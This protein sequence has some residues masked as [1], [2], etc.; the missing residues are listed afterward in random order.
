MATKVKREKVDLPLQ[1]RQ[2]TFQPSTLDEEARTVELVWTTGAIVRK[3]DWFDSPYEEELLLNDGAVRLGRLNGG[4]NLL[5]SHMG[6]ELSRVLG[7]VEEA[8]LDGSGKQRVGKARVRFSSRPDVEPFYHD[9]KDGIIRNVSVGYA[10]H[11]AQK[12][13]RKDRKI[14]LVRATDWEPL[15]LSMVAVPADVGAQVRSANER[16]FPCVV[17]MMGSGEMATRS[18]QEKAVHGTAEDIENVD[19]EQEETNE[20]ETNEEERTEEDIQERAKGGKGGG[21]SGGKGGGKSGGKGG[22]GRSQEE[23]QPQPQP[24]VDEA[25]IE[26]RVQQRIAEEEIR[27]ARIRKAVQVTG[28]NA[29]I[30]ERAIKAG[31]PANEAVDAILKKA[32]DEQAA[33]QIVSPT[34]VLP[35]EL[36]EVEARGR[37][38]RS[39]ILHR[40]DPTKFP[41][42]FGGENYQGFTLLEL[43]RHCLEAEGVRTAGLSRSELAKRSMLPGYGVRVG[44]LHTTSDF[45]NILADVA[46]KTLRAAYDAAVRTFAPFTRRTT[47]PDFKTVNRMQLGEAPTLIRKNEHGEFQRGTIG[48]SKE[49]YALVTYGRVFGITREVVVNDDLQAFTR[50]PALFGTAAAQK[51]S[52]VVWAVILANAAMGDGTAL[53]H[54][55]HGNLKASGSGAPSVTTIGADRAAMSKQTG[56]DGKTLINV[57]ARYILVPPELET[58]A[59]QLVASITAAT[60]ANVVPASIRSL[61]PISEPRLSVGVSLE[62]PDGSITTVA[63]SATTWYLAA[64]PNQID[65]IEYAYLEGEEGVSID[66][67]VGFDIDGVEVRARLDFAAKAIDWRG[68]YKDVGTA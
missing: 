29:E 44:G 52:D 56:L 27:C 48:E 34:S 36:D 1:F 53:F 38:V 7:V 21:K 39:A 24:V 20:E 19:L 33:R 32:A 18:S 4:A 58:T 12:I 5:D 66:S 41:F 64:D 45:A 6:Q 49:S 59:E 30:G 46:N 3:F 68:L 23:P 37:A 28:L 43:G 54:A 13:E 31:T 55:N 10:I 60:T 11:T 15:E 9:V 35:G 65:T 14:P 22:G 67:R 40:Y 17:E 51:E 42:E 57:M 8:W 47:V 63:G 50:M 16:V 2:A 62:N 61:V 25:E 26:R